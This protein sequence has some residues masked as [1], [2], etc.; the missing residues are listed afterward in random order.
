[1]REMTGPILELD[2]LS[3]SYAVRRGLGHRRIFALRQATLKVRR[4]ETFAVVGESGSGKTTLGRAMLRLVEP[5]G[6]RILYGKTDLT[7]LSAR[8]MRRLRPR[9]QMVFQDPYTSLNPGRRIRET[10]GDALGRAGVTRSGREARAAELLA[11]VGLES[12]ALDRLP[13]AFSGG[14]RQRIAIARALGTAPELLVADEP[15]SAL[16]VSVQAQIVNLLIDLKRKR[17]LTLVFISH[18]LRMV[19]NVA[20]NVAVMYFGEI[21]EI[22]DAAT[23]SAAPAHPYTRM[24]LAS[25]LRPETASA[26]ATIAAAGKAA[27][28]DMPSQ[29]NPPAGCPFRS[30]CPRAIDRCE[31]DPPRLAATGRGGLAACHNPSPGPGGQQET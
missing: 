24:L 13:A 22:T 29:L 1:M 31:I 4:G 11:D 5:S 14:Q 6:G 30:R 7:S 18:D 26:R 20:D 8:G 28:A 12:D 27:S 9:L 21:V 10:L 16:D 3:V 17:G 23:L 25:R 15:T 19:A 2:R